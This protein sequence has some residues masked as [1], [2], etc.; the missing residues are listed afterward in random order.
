MLGIS[1]PKV[2]MVTFSIGAAL[3]GLAGALL[4]PMNIV[5]PTI[6]VAYIGK[7]FITVISGGT[8]AVVGTATASTIFGS[9]SQLVTFQTTPILGQVALLVVAIIL[10]RILPGGITGRFFRRAIMIRSFDWD[11]HGVVLVAL[12]MIAILLLA[13]RLSDLFMLLQM[14]YFASMVI[15]ALSMGFVWGYGGIMCFGQSAFFG[16]GA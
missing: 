5:M 2:Y 14:T 7:A 6:G 4:A 13:P 12:S 11:R 10:L 8:A 1:P 9:I 3:T 15:F 16:L